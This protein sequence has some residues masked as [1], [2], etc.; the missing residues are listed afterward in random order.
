M[1][2]SWAGKKIPKGYAAK[3]RR[4][5]AGVFPKRGASVQAILRSN[6][7]PRARE[8]VKAT[9]TVNANGQ[10]V[11]KTLNGTGSITAI[12]LIQAG[13]SFFNRVGRR[14]LMKSLYFQGI[15]VPTGVA[16]A[17]GDFGRVLVVYDR[18]TNGANPVIADILQSTDQSGT[19]TTGAFSNLNLNNRE[20]FVILMDERLWLPQTFATGSEMVVTES[21][22]KTQFNIKRYINLKGLL[23]HFKADSSP[24]VIGD[25]STGGLF[26]V[27]LG[28]E[29]S[30][31]EGFAID[32]GWRLR[33]TDA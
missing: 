19:N 31:S 12:N 21:A 29:P 22:Q 8:E 25:I 7:G 18:Q 32:C 1:K 10:V 24:S 20:R 16:A 11:V 14:V 17:A 33:Y 2:R 30:G 6:R 5:V 15:V 4:M 28:G 23:T 3:R 27:T 26:L 9:D 13:S